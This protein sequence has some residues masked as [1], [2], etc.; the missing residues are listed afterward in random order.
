LAKNPSAS[1]HQHLL[2]LARTR[3]EDFNRLLVTYGNERLRYR[4]GRSPFAGRFVLKGAALFAVWMGR[5][6][7]PR[8]NRPGLGEYLSQIE[9]WLMFL[10]ILQISNHNQVTSLVFSPYSFRVSKRRDD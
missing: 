4:L 7:I 6:P 2:N 9:M 5:S 1:V 10:I 8:K 3:G